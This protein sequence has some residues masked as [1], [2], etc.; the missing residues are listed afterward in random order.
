MMIKPFE[1]SKKGV[2]VRCFNCGHQE[3]GV[4]K[5]KTLIVRNG[6]HALNNRRNPL[7]RSKC[8]QRVQKARKRL[9]QL[10][11][12]VCLCVLCVM[13]NDLQ[14]KGLSRPERESKLRDHL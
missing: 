1:F 9:P 6:H 13:V 10:S 8:G 14:P 2:L 12:C 11:L 5:E 4:G 7:M 3:T